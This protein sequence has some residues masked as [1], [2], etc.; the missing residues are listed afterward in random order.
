MIDLGRIHLFSASLGP[1]AAPALL[2]VHGWG[3]DGRE[4]SVH[5]ETLA[6]RFRVIVPDLRG[7]GRS[8][9]PEHGNTPL[10]MA[11]DLA[12]LVAVL[13]NG[14]MMAVGHSMGGQVVNLL[15][16]RHPQLVRSVVAFDPAHGAHGLEVDGIPGRL[17]AYREQGGRAAADF[18]AAAFSPQAPPG[19]RTAH[20]RTLLG[21]PDH[22]IAQA[23]AGMYTDPGAV[24]IRAHSEAYL[25]RRP[26]LA[27]TVWTS[28][29][30]AEWERNTLHVPGSRVELWPGVGH[31]LHEECPDRATRLIREWSG[32][33]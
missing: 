22:V 12:A 13:G 33:A 10:E 14:P 32:T 21:T 4:W 17:A 18:V 6:D 15:A 24:G 29:E 7:H 28:A 8:E 27:L 2:L 5:A 30:A 26:H 19:L 9:V 20:L 3:G 25:R 23:Y 11:D 31:Y 16:V 1:V